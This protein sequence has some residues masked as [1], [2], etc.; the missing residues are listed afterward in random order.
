MDFRIV[1]PLTRV[2]HGLVTIAQLRLEFSERQIERA[3]ERGRLERVACGV[4]R[5]VSSPA[6]FEQR[7]LAACLAAGPTA[8]AS[9][10]CAAA[11]WRFKDFPPGGVEISVERRRRT[12]IP[13]AVVH[14]SVV[15]DRFSTV[16]GVPVASVAR[17]LCDLTAVTRHWVVEHAVDDCLR[18]GLVALD[19][20]VATH[21]ALGGRGRRRSTVMRDILDWR[22][23]GLQPGDSAP[24]ARIAKLLVRAGLPAPTQQF[25]LR[26]G[27]RRVRIDLAN[28]AARIAIEYDGW[29]FHS[30]RAAFDRDRARANEL[31]L[32]GWTVLRF[33]SRST[34]EVVAGSV[35]SALARARDA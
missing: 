25:E 32:L 9:F 31:E 10:T 15:A 13:G 24:E 17:T 6:G 16:R 12:R 3:V 5:V 26:A 21:L 23:A 2:Q 20:L 18:R 27:G 35:R 14:Q 33:T 11:L 29:D 1:A 8:R 34:D 7:V 4:Y 19:D 28:P 30:T 22:V